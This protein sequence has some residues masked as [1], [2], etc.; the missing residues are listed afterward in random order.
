MDHAYAVETLSNFLEDVN[1]HLSKLEA[2][3][4][5][6]SGSRYWPDWPQNLAIELV[7]ARAIIDA[8]VPQALTE[9]GQYAPEGLG[10]W[11]LVRLATAEALGHAQHADEIAAFLRPASPVIQADALHPWVWQSA[12]PLWAA[13]AHQDAVLAAA[14]TVNRRLQQKLGRH[15]IGEKDLCMQSF[16]MK[17]PEEGKPRLRFNGDRSTPTWRARQD[18][19]KYTSAGAFLALRNL[20][21]HEDEVDWSQQEALEYLATF[22][23]VARWIEECVVETAPRAL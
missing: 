8:Y 11:Q 19:A 9:L 1:A 12:A 14:R 4:E 7:R 10:Y 17:A 6:T 23:V 20:A 16:D 5:D 21:A 2:A 18:G 15:D 22:S 13:E 3:N